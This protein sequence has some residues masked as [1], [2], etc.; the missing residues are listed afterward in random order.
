MTFSAWPDIDSS[1][2]PVLVPVAEQLHQLMHQLQARRDAGER[3]EPPPEQVLRVFR[4]PLSA[5]KV[6]VVGQDPYPTP[7]HAVGLSFALAPD[8]RPIARSLTNI[9]IERQDDLG[10]PPAASGDLSAWEAQGVFLLNRILTVSAHAA[11]SHRKLGWEA[12][13]EAVVQ[14]LATRS[15]PL[16]VIL[17]GA[18]ARSLAPMFTAP[19]TLVIESAHPS[20]L[21]ARRGFFGSKPFSRTNTFLTELGMEP[22]DWATERPTQT[23]PQPT[24]FD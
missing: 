5:V 2:Y 22:I 20:P 13:T 9:F 17:W 7:G 12:I 6:L 3:I 14:A 24:L 23:T 15:T 8:V 10:I 16:A 1:W 18:Q 21:S 19:N 11:G 4:M